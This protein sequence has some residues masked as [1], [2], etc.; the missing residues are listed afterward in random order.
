MFSD[1]N[2]NSYR[3][4]KRRQQTEGFYAVPTL[5]IINIFFFLIQVM[6]TQQ[7]G[8]YSYSPVTEALALNGNAIKN[9]QIWRIITYMFLHG[10]FWHI[11]INM[12]GVY[13]F[14]SMLEQRIG[15]DR[16]LFLYFASGIAGAFLWLIFNIYTIIPCVGASGAL[17]GVLVAAAM[18][19]PNTMIMLLIPP[20]PLKLKTFVIIYALIETFATVGSFG[21]NVAHLVH[22]GGL[23]AGYFYMRHAFPA[24]TYDILKFFKTKNIRDK[25]TSSRRSSSKAAKKWKFT[26]SKSYNLDEILDKISRSGIN[27]L[28]QEEMDFLRKAREGMKNKK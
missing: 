24:E 3:Y 21:G 20:I 5:I 16:F 13:L 12:W 22:I 18:M 1:R 19:F 14:G 28:S 10:G 23:I 26:G 27:S 6:T 8:V 25:A 9:F 7:G 17:F 4:Y 11:A 15:S 2:Y